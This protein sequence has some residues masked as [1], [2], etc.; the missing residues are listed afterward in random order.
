ME[1]RNTLAG[2]RY[3]RTDDQRFREA[4]KPT[5][6]D[7]IGGALRRAFKI[8]GEEAGA[9]DFTTLLRTLDNRTE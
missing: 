6:G 3:C 4:P 1:Y 8:D 7:G 5:R 2:D 9:N